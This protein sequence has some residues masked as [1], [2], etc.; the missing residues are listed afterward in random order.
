MKLTRQSVRVLSAS[1]SALQ[2]V[3]FAGRKCYKSE[4]KITENSYIEFVENLIKNGHY[5]VLEHAS[6]SFEIVTD[7]GIMAEL[8]RHRHCS[9]SVQSTR[10]VNLAKAGVEFIIPTWMNV[11]EGEYNTP[12]QSEDVVLNSWINH[13]IACE[14]TY[15]SL[16]YSGWKPQ[17]ARSVLPNSLKTELVMTCNLAQLRH[18][19]SER[20]TEKAHPQM[21]ELMGLLL[22]SVKSEFY[23][24]FEDFKKI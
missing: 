6:I 10:F 22:D 24:V 3:E 2:L 12:I 13:L 8:T 20:L 23:P 17:Q 1:K 7:R 16:I 9:F 19:L 4:S 15:K 5:S 14:N 21:I 18:V 11:E